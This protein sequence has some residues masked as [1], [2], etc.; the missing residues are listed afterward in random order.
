MNNKKYYLVSY[1]ARLKGNGFGF[2]REYISV[3]FGNEFCLKSFEDMVIIEA[4]LGDNDVNFIARTEVTQS[5]YEYNKGLANG[6]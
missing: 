5:E 4:G 3:D 1:Y 2:G 6:N